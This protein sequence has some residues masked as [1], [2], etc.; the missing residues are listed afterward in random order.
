MPFTYI[1][2]SLKIDNWYDV[3]SCNILE[4]RFKQHRKGSVRST[5]PK[6]P[7]KLIF[8]K[9][10]DTMTE[11]KKHELYLKSFKGYLEKK[12][13]IQDNDKD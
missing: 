11:E 9:E 7:L 6:R 5:K 13:I 12:K 8:N 3:G 1:W 2:K 10:F 4:E